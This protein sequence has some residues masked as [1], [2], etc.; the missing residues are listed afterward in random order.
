VPQ[1]RQAWWGFFTSWHCGQT[2]R[3]GAFR[4]LWVRLLSLRDLDVLCFG[5]AMAV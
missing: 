1:D 2:E 4:N 5:F 3:L